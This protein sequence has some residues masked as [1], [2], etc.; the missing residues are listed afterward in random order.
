MRRLG[1]GSVMHSLD[2]GKNS[3]YVTCTGPERDDRLTFHDNE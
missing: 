2:R 1:P 3:E